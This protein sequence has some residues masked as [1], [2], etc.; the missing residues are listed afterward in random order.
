MLWLGTLVDGA[1]S[2][3][4]VPD[5]AAEEELAEYDAGRFE[6]AGEVL[7]VEWSDHQ[8][9]RRPRASPFERG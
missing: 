6:H 9:S 4:L 3:I 8:E 2:D 7:R 5:D 1:F